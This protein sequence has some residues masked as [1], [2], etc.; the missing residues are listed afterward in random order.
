MSWKKRLWIILGLMVALGLCIVLGQLAYNAV[1][2]SMTQAGWR[3]I[4]AE[5]PIGTPRV[6]VLAVMENIAWGHYEC[7]R[8]SLSGEVSFEDVYLFGSKDIDQ[9]GVVII[10]YDGTPPDYV[11]ATRSSLE[12]YRLRTVLWGCSPLTM[13]DKR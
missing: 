2:S 11:I 6:E 10:H 12:G 13:Q 4:A 5:V 1:Q 9:M 7:P 8:K 3:R